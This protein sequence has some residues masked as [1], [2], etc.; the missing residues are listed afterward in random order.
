MRDVPFPGSGAIYVDNIVDSSAQSTKIDI[1]E[2]CE[3]AALTGQ[4]FL[5][6]Q[7]CLG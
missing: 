2:R 3:I 5:L 4:H 6:C 7:Q 1:C